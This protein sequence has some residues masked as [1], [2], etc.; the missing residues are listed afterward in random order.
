M[1]KNLNAILEKVKE[2]DDSQLKLAKEIGKIAYCL[3]RFYPGTFSY[4]Q[5]SIA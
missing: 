1:N 4:V 5:S 2:D 3:H